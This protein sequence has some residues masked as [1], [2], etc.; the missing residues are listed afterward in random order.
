[1]DPSDVYGLE[2]LR[3]LECLR[4]NNFSYNWIGASLE[5]SR[6]CISSIKSVGLEGLLLIEDIRLDTGQTGDRLFI[7]NWTDLSCPGSLRLWQ[8][9]MLV[10]GELWL[11]RCGQQRL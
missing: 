2:G 11:R 8:R 10:A 5:I 3:P 9:M 6:S 4:L 1:M 7:Y